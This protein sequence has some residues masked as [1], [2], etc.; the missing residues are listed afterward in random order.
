MSKDG[1]I[2]REGPWYRARLSWADCCRDEED[3]AETERWRGVD[4]SELVVDGAS[5][6]LDE[7][8]FAPLFV[9]DME[10][11]AGRRP[12]PGGGPS[13]ATP[14]IFRRCTTSRAKA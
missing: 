3:E 11:D 8:R 1:R 14:L 2:V 12:S 4:D 10:E 7:S 6:P 5:K 13:P 9:R